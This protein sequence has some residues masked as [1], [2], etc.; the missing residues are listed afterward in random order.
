MESNTVGVK[1]MRA[2]ILSEVLGGLF[3]RGVILRTLAVSCVIGC[4][5]GPTG[6]SHTSAI[7]YGIVRNSSGAPVS[8]AQVR[9]DAFSTCSSSGPLTSMPAQ[10]STAGEYRTVITTI[11]SPQQICVRSSLSTAGS[12]VSAQGAVDVRPADTA[13][14]SLRLDLSTP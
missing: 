10:T 13:L 1:M 3:V 7:I 12:S 8:N 11:V 5:S 2:T 6:F 14:D 9:V 4:T